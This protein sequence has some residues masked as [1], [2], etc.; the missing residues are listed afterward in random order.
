MRSAARPA[1]PARHRPSRTAGQVGPRHQD[2]LRSSAQIRSFCRISRLAL[3]SLTPQEVGTRLLR[4]ICRALAFTRAE[5]W[6]RGSDRARIWRFASHGPGYLIADRPTGMPLKECSFSRLVLR[7]RQ[8][9][10]HPRVPCAGV[11]GRRSN[12]TNVTSLFGAPLVVRSRPIGLLYAD[13]G[14]RPFGM[15]ALDLELGTALA[16]LC[17]EVLERALSHHQEIKR[18]RQMALLNE[19]HE[20]ITA[21]EGLKILLPRVARI[22]RRQTHSR[23]VI[24]ALLSSERREFEVAAVAGSGGPRPLGRRFDVVGGPPWI[25]LCR[26]ATL[27]KRPAALSDFQSLPRALTWWPGVRSALSVPIRSRGGVMGALRFE[28]ERP[29]AFDQEDQTVLANVGEQIGHAVR[30][31]RLLDDLRRRQRDVQAV[32]ASLERM[33][34]EDRRRIAREL[35]DELAQSMTAAKINLALLRQ[36]LPDAQPEARRAIRET[37]RIVNGTIA[38]IRRISMDLRPALLDDLGLVPALK[39]LADTFS[40]RTGIR[41]LVETDDA[42]TPIDVEVKTLLYRFVQEALTNVFRHARARAVQVQLSTKGRG[43]RA[44]V[45]DDGTGIRRK[46]GRKQPGLGLLGMRERI[47][48][49]GGTLTIHSR[50]GA[51]TSLVAEVPVGGR[52][53]VVQRR[54][55]APAPATAAVF[56]KARE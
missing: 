49:V 3:K 8:G 26:R 16:V 24:I 37:E 45:H 2:Y 29:F 20:L 39:W 52:A 32:S 11:F 42:A 31:E 15:S 41:V 25:R 18:H 13:H 34:E 23:G 22:L 10:H 7:R 55:P 1:E 17:G 4:E 40:R 14:G 50:A 33:L 28:S 43:L 38:D 54:L 35:H 53:G 44:I 19:I 9:V 12:I 47:E 21:Q 48:R 6:L 5:I 30:R 56:S 46:G 36:L 51:G 27:S